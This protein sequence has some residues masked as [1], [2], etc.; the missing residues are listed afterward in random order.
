[1]AASMNEIRKIA[2]SSSVF[3]AIASKTLKQSLNA[4]ESGVVVQE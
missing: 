2:G 4:V 3:K 1:M